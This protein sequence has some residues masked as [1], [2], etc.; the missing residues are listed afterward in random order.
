M[1]QTPAGAQ[2]H[3]R[4]IIGDDFKLSSLNY[5]GP[6]RTYSQVIHVDW[7][8]DIR[9]NKTYSCNTLWLLDDMT[10]ENGA[11]R[12]IP[13]SHKWYVRPQRKM[14]GQDRKMAL[15]NERLIEAK[16]GSVIVVNGNLWHGGTQNVSGSDR[17]VLQGYFIH[18]AHNQ[19][20]YQT[21]LVTEDTLARL[22]TADKKVLDINYLPS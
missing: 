10:P 19:Q 15:D 12:V 8:Q 11:T 1:L 16:A 4:S 13:G 21:D 17:A 7:F 5:R 2:C 20:Q 14:E 22:S 9:L 3:Q 6:Q 18:G